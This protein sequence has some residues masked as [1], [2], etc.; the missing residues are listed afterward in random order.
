LNPR[1][2]SPR[3]V[4]DCTLAALQSREAALRTEQA[5][6]GLD[7]LREV[8]LHPL[9]AEAFGAAG[10][11]VFA[12]QPYPVPPSRRAKR[13]QRERC[14]LVLTPSP[15]LR[16]RDEVDMARTFDAGLGT[17]FEP[18]AP[19][20]ARGTGQIDP[21]EAFWIEVKTV[22]QFTYTHGVPEPNG[23]Y[24]AELRGA[25]H[26]LTK[27]EEDAVIRSA[28]LLLVLFAASPEVA[29]HDG[30]VIAARALEKGLPLASRLEGGF[31]VLDRIG[32]RWCSVQVFEVR[33]T[34]WIE[35]VSEG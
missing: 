25:L 23:A 26:D 4:L 8:E 16:I 18:L 30:G 5:V 3:D 15:D 28:A 6:R 27:L 13:S 22:G 17:L 14:D 29:S 31:P 34:R 2:W 19:A 10:L 35:R 7:A 21:E 33:C 20:L 9:I 24:G 1:V 32:N 12:E 11:G